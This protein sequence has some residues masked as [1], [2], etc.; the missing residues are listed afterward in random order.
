MDETPEE[1]IEDTQ[2][3]RNA[4]FVKELESLINTYS[5]E[6]G[7]DTPDFVLA[8]YLFGCL[9]AFHTAANVRDTWYGLK[10]FAKGCETLAVRGDED[11]G[12]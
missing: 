8:E 1:P 12:I 10:H 7:S 9:L 3:T 11:M 4:N 2:E 6:N 5:M